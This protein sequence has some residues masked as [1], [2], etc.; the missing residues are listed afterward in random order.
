VTTKKLFP[1]IQILRGDI[2]DKYN[3]EQPIEVSYAKTAEL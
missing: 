3:R 2:K 1:F